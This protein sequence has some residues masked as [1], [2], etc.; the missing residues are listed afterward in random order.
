MRHPTTAL[1]QRLLK[2]HQPST[3]AASDAPQQL[4]LLDSPLC[5]AWR[6]RSPCPFPPLAALQHMVDHQAA[7]AVTQEVDCGANPVQQPVYGQDDCQVC[8]ERMRE[9]PASVLRYDM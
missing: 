4:R 2:P 5:K 6:R 7:K 8:N 9:R 1:F 3:A